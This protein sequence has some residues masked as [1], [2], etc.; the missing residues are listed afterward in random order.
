MNINCF[1]P[2]YIGSIRK[3]QFYAVILRKFYEQTDTDMV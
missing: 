2:H 1:F 3:N